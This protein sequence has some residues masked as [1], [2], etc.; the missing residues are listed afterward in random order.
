MQSGPRRHRRTRI[1]ET[2][3][4]VR[5]FGIVI[6]IVALVAAVVAVACYWGSGRVYRAREGGRHD[7]GRRTG[8]PSPATAPPTGAGPQEEIRQML[9]AKS[10]RREARGEA[11]S[12]S[13]PRW[14][15]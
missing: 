14:R 8:G 12:T 5:H 2:V 9:E 7:P 6:F 13:T 1:G 3:G 10:A 4:G 11:R 15:P